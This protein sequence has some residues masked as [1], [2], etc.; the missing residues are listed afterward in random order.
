MS[1][2]VSSTNNRCPSR[3]LVLISRVSPG[4][5]V[6]WALA[7]PGSERLR[8]FK[9]FLRV[10]RNFHLAPLAPQDAGAI[11]QKRAALDAEILSTVQTLLLDDIEQLAGLLVAVR[12][13]REGEL[14][15]RDELVVRFHAVARNTDDVDA[16]LAERAVQIPEILAFARAAARHVLRIEVDDQLAARRRLQRPGAVAVRGQREILDLAADFRSCHYL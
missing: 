5:V 13:Q 8:C 15:L 1:T 4:A 6:V 12:E 16:C 3:D 10:A 14:F 9:N 7:G 2:F 11:Q